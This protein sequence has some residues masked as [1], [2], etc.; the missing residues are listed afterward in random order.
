MVVKILEKPKTKLTTDVN[1]T[2]RDIAQKQLIAMILHLQILQR[3]L[4]A[5]SLRNLRLEHGLTG[6]EVAKQVGITLQ[7]ISNYEHGRQEPNRETLVKILAVFDVTY[8]D[9]KQSLFFAEE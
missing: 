7:A 1:Q 9:F 3:R 2:I 8:E 6:T 4:I 5:T